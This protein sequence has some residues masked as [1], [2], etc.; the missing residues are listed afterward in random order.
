MLTVDGDRIRLFTGRLKDHSLIPLAPQLT[1]AL[2]RMTLA[3]ALREQQ[4]EHPSCWV[5]VVEPTRLER[6]TRRRCRRLNTRQYR[7][8]RRQQRLGP[9]QGSP[10]RRHFRITHEPPNLR[11]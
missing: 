9:E 5:K 3:L 7:L 6:A 11:W 8:G 1:R 4:K 10:S 2:A